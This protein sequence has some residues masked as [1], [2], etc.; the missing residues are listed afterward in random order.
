[1]QKTLFVTHW[2]G[3][4]VWGLA[5]LVQAA[6]TEEVTG[7]R[8]A[9]LSDLH[10]SSSIGSL[11]ANALLV[12][13]DVNPSV[14]KFQANDLIDPFK[15]CAAQMFG[16]D[17]IKAHYT[18]AVKRDLAKLIKGENG[19]LLRGGI[20][21]FLSSPKQAIHKPHHLMG[22]FLE[23]YLGDIPMDD[24]L[25]SSIVY[26]HNMDRVE[27][28][29][30]ASLKQDRFDSDAW[31]AE[32]IPNH[33]SHH[34]LRDIIMATTAAPTVFGSVE[35]DG[36]NYLDLDHQHS[37]N[38]ALT[39]AIESLRPHSAPT[40]ILS[41]YGPPKPSVKMLKITCGKESELRWDSALYNQQGPLAMMQD[42]NR[43][44]ARDQQ[45]IDHRLLRKMIGPDNITWI[46]TDMS[47]L[48]DCETDQ[49]PSPSLFNGNRS[50]LEK[51]QDRARTYAAMQHDAIM[52]YADTVTETRASEG[53]VDALTAFAPA[54]NC[55]E[56][57]QT[58]NQDQ[59]EPLPTQ[60][61]RWGLGRLLRRAPR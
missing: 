42:L 37:P 17:G 29:C 30:F 3:G 52:R 48:P 41:A 35:I 46:G 16:P 18:H 24:L 14:P 47:E 57:R 9:D 56:P 55:N 22:I 50:N 49:S 25:K 2:P 10:I 19:G 59:A 34:R 61:Q 58:D 36:K 54:A 39:L 4:G 8:M 6:Y 38:G 26:A 20:A 33:G 51:I 40:P 53:S 1:M 21:R 28:V 11:A 32:I 60:P 44:T 43:M 27:R 45:N 12:P 13:S 23:N 31:D 15:E 7:M 5:Q